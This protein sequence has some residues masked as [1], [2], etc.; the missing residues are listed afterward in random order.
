MY[1]IF[2]VSDD[3]NPWQLRHVLAILSVQTMIENRR[4]EFLDNLL[5][6]ERFLYRVLLSAMPDDRHTSWIKYRQF[7][8][9]SLVF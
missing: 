8:L 6:D 4:R 7:F 5:N 9:C 2:A 3:E 1:N